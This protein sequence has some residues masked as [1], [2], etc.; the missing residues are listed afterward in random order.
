MLT[1]NPKAVD[2]IECRLETD[3][4]GLDTFKTTTHR[5]VRELGEF[6]HCGTK[7]LGC[8]FVNWVPWR[9]VRRGDH[10]W[11]DM[12]D[13]EIVRSA[14]PS[15]AQKYLYE[16]G[17][18]M[19]DVKGLDKESGVTV[20]YLGKAEGKKGRIN[21]YLD[22]GNDSAVVFSAVLSWG[23]NVAFRWKVFDDGVNLGDEEAKFLGVY[24]YAC[25]DALNDGPRRLDTVLR[26]IFLENGVAKP[27][28]PF[29]E[30][31][32]VVSAEVNRGGA[33]STVRLANFIDLARMDILQQAMRAGDQWYSTNFASS[34]QRKLRWADFLVHSDETGDFLRHTIVKPGL[35]GHL[36]A[37][38]V[39]LH[40]ET[41]KAWRIE[42]REW[43]KW[44]VAECSPH[45]LSKSDD[46]AS[47]EYEST[48]AFPGISTSSYVVV[49]NDD[50]SSDKNYG[51]P[52]ID[53][54]EDS[55]FKV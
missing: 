48:M 39:I 50:T 35:N 33:S 20:L 3:K 47:A 11:F 22:N 4:K 13:A 34:L 23:C 6:T 43:I 32:K 37:R 42:R 41:K 28:G 21:Q 7:P 10:G 40:D 15:E 18:V 27:R 25:N 54:L 55:I 38:A 9:F 29:T 1:K 36:Q 45:G 53:D 5:V 52:A 24:D 17:I 8:S 12:H 26:P 19:D 31:D 49:R 46:I 14:L 30:H 44:S 51:K 16:Y 2:F